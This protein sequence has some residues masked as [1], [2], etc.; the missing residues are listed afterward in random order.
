MRTSLLAV[1]LVVAAPV[2]AQDEAPMDDGPD[3]VD[4]LRADGRF[5]TLLSAVGTAGLA[6]ALAG[7]GPLTVF[8]PTDSAFA[9]LP[10]GAL[11]ELSVEDLQGILLGHVAE[12]AVDGAT[13]A[14]AGE[15]MSLAGTALT[16]VAA[17]GGLT[18]NGATVVDADVAASNGVVHVIDT[19]LLP[20]AE[21]P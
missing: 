6:D 2:M 3:I 1:L 18:V 20:V 19:V 11:A 14:A 17:D 16:F 12:G 10:E 5:S 15:G 7:A 4:V 21:A 9:A 13:A 8:A